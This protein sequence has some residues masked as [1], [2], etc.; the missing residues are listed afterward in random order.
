MKLKYFGVEAVVPFIMGC[1][2]TSHNYPVTRRHASERRRS[3][4]HRHQNLKT[5][6]SMY[7]LFSDFDTLVLLKLLATQVTF[8][9]GTAFFFFNFVNLKHRRLHSPNH[10]RRRYSL[11]SDILCRNSPHI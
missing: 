2:A 6:S 4:L 1:D 11:E 9:M 7:V 3:Q 10:H 8:K 5:L